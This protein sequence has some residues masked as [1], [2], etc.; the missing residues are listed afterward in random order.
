MLIRLSILSVRRF[1]TEFQRNCRRIKTAGPQ[2]RAPSFCRMH[3]E[4][5]ARLQDARRRAGAIQR[6]LRFM[7][8][9]ARRVRRIQNGQS[10][11]ARS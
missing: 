11:L 10:P 6:K 4:K 2:P 5:R 8:R 7:R 1:D 3:G 9:L